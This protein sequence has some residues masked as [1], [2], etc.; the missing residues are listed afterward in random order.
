MPILLII[1]GATK[2]GNKENMKKTITATL[3]ALLLSAVAGYAQASLGSDVSGTVSYALPSTVITLEV[4]AVVETFHAGPYAKYAQKYLGINAKTSDGSSVQV[5]NVKMTPSIEADPSA[6]Y[7]V[8][9]AKG[10]ASFLALTS[11]GLVCTGDAFGS[12][13]E[14]RFPSV[15]KGDFTGKAISS[16]LTSEATT[17]YRS[18]DNSRVAIQQDM[19][20]QK[21][22]E[23]RAKETAETIVKLRNK[24]IAIAT[25][26]TD[27]S[28][29]GE[30]LAAA[31][32]EIEDLE[33]E[34]LSMFL[35][36]SEY[37]T[38][39]VKYDVVPDASQDRQVYVAFRLSD[40]AGLVP[41]DDVS[42]KP[43]VL[44]LVPQATAS[45]GTAGLKGNVAYY[46]I[47][48][49]CTVKLRDGSDVLIQSRIPV[50]Q[51][52]TIGAIT[53]NTK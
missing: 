24:K 49:T 1:Y 50:Y 38:Q 39:K 21:S 31:L 36:Y 17:L 22:A 33:R 37:Q 47:P 45:D 44:E 25:G 15:A 34:Y 4:E 18:E 20:V 7:Q 27:A 29:S 48:A 28:F 23:T 43:Y 10:G 51:L 12:S 53:I 14:W 42:G 52:G 40:T 46:R 16:N 26:D 5:T 9:V 8:S 32:A 30:A 2:D 11:Q 41:A 35:G 13:G 3:A 19:I 6:R